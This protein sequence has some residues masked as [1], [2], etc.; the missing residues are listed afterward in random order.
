MLSRTNSGLSSNGDGFEFNVITA[1]VLGG[2]SSSGG[3]G[4]V[5][6]ALVGVLIVGFLENGLLLMNVSEYM[7]RHPDAGGSGLRHSIPREKRAHQEDQ[8]HQC[9]Q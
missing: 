6:G 3:K 5:F 8:G 1:C 7:Q 9:Q 2:V 4:T